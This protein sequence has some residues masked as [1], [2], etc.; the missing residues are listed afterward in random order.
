MKTSYYAK[1]KTKPGAIAISVR[2]PRWVKGKIPEYQQLA[3]NFY[4]QI[5]YDEYLKKF[6]AQLAK[7]DAQKVWDELHQLT[8]GVEP[9]LLCYEAPPFD[10]RNFC[11]RHMVAEWFKRELGK[12]VEELGMEK[13]PETADLF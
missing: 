1:Y 6:N 13:I 5:P 9:V 10:K 3:P 11:H 7:L 2:P 8:G 4:F 12:D